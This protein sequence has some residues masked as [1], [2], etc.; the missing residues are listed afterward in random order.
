[1]GIYME[2]LGFTK[3]KIFATSQLWYAGVEKEDV[4]SFRLRKFD[5][6]EFIGDIESA[7]KKSYSDWRSQMWDKIE[8]II[9]SEYKEEYV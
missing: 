6:E 3:D 2:E 7:I 5:D 4:N 9:L 8:A 1:M